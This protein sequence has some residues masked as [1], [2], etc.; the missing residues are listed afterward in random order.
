MANMF[1]PAAQADAWIAEWAALPDAGSG[2][3]YLEVRTGAAP[4]TG[5]AATGTLLATL[6]LSD[7]AF[8]VTDNVATI[9]SVTSDASADATGTAGYARIFDSD[10]AVC[11]DLTVGVTGSGAGV[12]L[13]STSIVATQIVAL[14]GGTVT[15]PIGP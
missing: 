9:D 6:T 11:A 5:T 15:I 10:D 2:A 3:G 4:G 8:S 13:A 12:E 14:T 7:P 1:V